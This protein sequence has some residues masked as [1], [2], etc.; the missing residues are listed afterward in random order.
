MLIGLSGGSP[1]LAQSSD[2]NVVLRVNT[3]SAERTVELYQ[4]LLGRPADIAALKGSRI[5]LATTSLL[6]QRPLD[7][8]E[9]VRSLEAAKFNQSQGEDLFRM[10]DARANQAAI[11]ELLVEIGRRNFAQKVVSTVAQLFPGRHRSLDD[12]PG[13]FCRLWAPEYRR[14]CPQGCVAWRCSGICR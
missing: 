4:G 7:L 14:F 6:W 5:A 10:Q 12:D 11:K 9:L 2:F 1:A 3:E 13:L 8:Q